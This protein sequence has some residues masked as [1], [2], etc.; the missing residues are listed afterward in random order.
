MKRFAT[1]PKESKNLRFNVLEHFVASGA[2]GIEH[3]T[4]KGFDPI[5]NPLDKLDF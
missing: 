1:I 5:Q 3:I 4:T 2:I